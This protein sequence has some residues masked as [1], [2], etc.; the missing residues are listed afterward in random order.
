M[1]SICIMGGDGGGTLEACNPSPTTERECVCVC[2]CVWKG[3][4]ERDAGRN[5]EEASLPKPSL[6]LF[7]DK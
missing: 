5:P 6:F 4:R 7:S 2:V 3:E 1:A